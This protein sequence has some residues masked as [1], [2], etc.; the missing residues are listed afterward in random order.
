M[1]VCIGNRAKR[2]KFVNLFG[3][4]GTIALHKCQA[5][6]DSEVGSNGA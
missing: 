1:E 6:S 5:D 4:L 2:G 3:L